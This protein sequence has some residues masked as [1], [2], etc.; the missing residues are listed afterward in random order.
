MVTFEDGEEVHLIRQSQHDIRNNRTNLKNI[1][2]KWFIV[3]RAIPIPWFFTHLDK[4]INDHCNHEDS[5][6]CNS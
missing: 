4:E 3:W 1:I 5:N 6:A 2:T